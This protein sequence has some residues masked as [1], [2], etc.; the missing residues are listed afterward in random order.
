MGT[1]KAMSSDNGIVVWNRKRRM[2]EIWTQNEAMHRWISSTTV[3]EAEGNW[4]VTLTIHDHTQTQ[5]IP[6]SEWRGGEGS[7][8]WV[9]FEW[10]E[11][12]GRELTV[13]YLCYYW[14]RFFLCY[15]CVVLYL[16]CLFD[17]DFSGDYVIELFGKWIA[18]HRLSKC[19]SPHHYYR[20]IR[21][22]R[23][24]DNWFWSHHLQW[25][26][27]CTLWVSWIHRMGWITASVIGIMDCKER[28]E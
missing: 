13:V 25:N 7:E 3:L 16:I 23:W 9:A 5:P 15:Y 26:I 10:V 6:I 4:I 27:S 8:M 11:G 2:T 14:S 28:Q 22:Q 17:F 1:T 21:F 19:K 24:K 20:C 18:T 12:A